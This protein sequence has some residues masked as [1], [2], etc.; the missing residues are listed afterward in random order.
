M[1]NL[2]AILVLMLTMSSCNEVMNQ[3]DSDRC[4]AFTQNGTR[5]QNKSTSRSKYCR[6]HQNKRSGSSSTSKSKSS[7]AK[8]KATTQNGKRCSRPAKKGGFCTQHYKQKK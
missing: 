6:T 4:Q 7:K 8:C 3:L 2:L 1:K 5:C